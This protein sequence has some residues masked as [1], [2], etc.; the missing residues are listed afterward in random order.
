MGLMD[1]VDVW[2]VGVD[3]WV[4]GWIDEIDGWGRPIFI[5]R[6]MGYFYM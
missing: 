6:W 4:V 1:G 2:V 3:G 5:C